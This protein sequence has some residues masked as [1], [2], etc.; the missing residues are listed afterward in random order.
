MDDVC[1][2]VQ[3]DKLSY[4]KLTTFPTLVENVVQLDK[5]SYLRL[6]TFPAPEE[7][8]VKLDKLIRPI[9]TN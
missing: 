1:D 7:K 8:L 6:T 5:L 4:L 2:L 9:W 3:L